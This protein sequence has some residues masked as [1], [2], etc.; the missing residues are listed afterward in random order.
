MHFT[1][2][3]CFTVSEKVREKYIVK[4]LYQFVTNFWIKGTDVRN[5]MIAL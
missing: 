1:G 3:K 4:N 2:K 5:V